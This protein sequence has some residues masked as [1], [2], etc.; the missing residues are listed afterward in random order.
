MDGLHSRRWRAFALAGLTS[1]GAVAA[2]AGTQSVSQNTYLLV[3][4]AVTQSVLDHQ[5]SAAAGHL[6]EGS[7]T[8]SWQKTGLSASGSAF[9][10]AAAGDGWLLADVRSAVSLTST[11]PSQQSVM[12]S[13][14]VSATLV[15]D[16]MIT[17]DGCVAGTTGYMLA[18][19]AFGTNQESFGSGGTPSTGRNFYASAAIGNEYWAALDNGE[20][21]GNAWGF[22]YQSFVVGQ[23][24]HLELQLSVDVYSGAVSVVGDGS[25]SWIVSRDTSGGHRVSWGGIRDVT[26]G[27]Q[28]VTNFNAY[29][30][31]GRVNYA[32]AAVPLVPE[33]G[34]WALMLGGLAALGALARRRRD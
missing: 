9:T 1:F 14:F 10:R 28:A 24:I 27:G 33:P 21:V 26:V 18:Q 20:W 8:S 5:P 7:L 12:V 6:Y 11:L 13:S 29:S 31:D 30:L 22:S 25:E 16:F 15:D 3:N 19:Y 23:P 4:G 32:L 34:T 17:C 2:Q